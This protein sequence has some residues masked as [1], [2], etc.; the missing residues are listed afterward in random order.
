MLTQRPSLNAEAPVPAAAGPSR[1]PP[2]P[3]GAARGP[4]GP[5]TSRGPG[6]PLP[7]PFGGGEQARWFG[8]LPRR[9]SRQSPLSRAAEPGPAGT[10]RRPHTARPLALRPPN[11]PETIRS[12]PGPAPLQRS[13]RPG[14]GI[15]LGRLPAT[16]HLSLS[17]RPIPGLRTGIEPTPKCRPKPQRGIRPPAGIRHNLGGLIGDPANNAYHSSSAALSFATSGFTISW[18]GA[19]TGS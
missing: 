16:R 9:A 13:R 2:G 1:I 17:A 18:S 10:P 12:T 8:R 5:G 19:M 11:D 6:R 3:A 15:R 14:I 7:A 4:K